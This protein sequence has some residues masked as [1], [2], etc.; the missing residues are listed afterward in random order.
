MNNGIQLNKYSMIRLNINKHHIYSAVYG[1][2]SECTDREC[3]HDVI[4]LMDQQEFSSVR[5]IITLVLINNGI[6]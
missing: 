3:L 2:I 4:R 6:N 5:L 1:T